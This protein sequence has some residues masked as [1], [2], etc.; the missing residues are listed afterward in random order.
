MK[1][2]QGPYGKDSV[3]SHDMMKFASC[4]KVHMLA[5][6]GLALLAW[7]AFSTILFLVA[8]VLLFIV[9]VSAPIVLLDRVSAVL[10][11]EKRI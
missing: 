9:A 8:V 7:V 3:I 4:S 6:N 10:A 11:G 1:L 2:I 5:A